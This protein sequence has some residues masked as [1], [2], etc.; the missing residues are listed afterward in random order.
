MCLCLYLFV[1]LFVRVCVHLCTPSTIQV[2]AMAGTQGAA[3]KVG[4]NGG[5]NYLGS[6]TY[7]N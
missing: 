3:P 5:Y 2:L 1:C 4:G 7:S 6:A